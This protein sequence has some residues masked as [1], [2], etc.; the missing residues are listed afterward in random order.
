MRLS[1]ALALLVLPAAVALAD[2]PPKDAP[3][4]PTTP[5]PSFENPL[6]DAK[7]GETLLY[8]VRDLEGKWTRYYE[9]RVLARDGEDVLIET[10]LTDEKGQKDWGRDPD[11]RNTGW[12]KVEKEMKLGPTQRWVKERERD[13]VLT[14][15]E[16]PRAAV[17][18]KRRVI[19]EP[20][21]F[22]R[23]E[24]KRRPREV[25]YSHDVPA[26]GRVRMFPAQQEG[27]RMLLSWDK[28][29]PAEYC[30]KR[31]AT[32]PKPEP[33]KDPPPAM[34]GEPAM[35]EPGMGEPGMGEPGKGEP[36]MDEPGM[37]D[38]GKRPS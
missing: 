19:D 18:C 30:A 14:I 17:R 23:P 26:T 1:P 20:A 38:R 35:G 3:K 34:D 16:P 31:A 25:W 7:A 32:Y 12:R 22:T 27:E 28:V 4:P 21:D 11:G 13:E 15:G 8:R 33:P 2:E 6:Y 10:I 24:G 36:G 5:L 9:E 37:A 29:L